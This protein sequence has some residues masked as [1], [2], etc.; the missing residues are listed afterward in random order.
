MAVDA[1]GRAEFR[2]S[3]AARETPR[4]LAVVGACFVIITVTNSLF[5]PPMALTTIVLNGLV[6]LLLLAGALVTQRKSLP[7]RATPWVAAG[8]ALAMVTDGQF[9][10]WRDPD[11]PAFA[12]VL[13]IVV[14]Y[15]PLTLAWTP[16]LVVAVPMVVGSLAVARAFPPSQTTDWAIASVAAIAIGM[17]LLWLRLRS[18]AEAGELSARVQ[19]MATEDHLTG[20]LNRHGV[21][22]RIPSLAA[23]AAERRNE[24]V[25]AVFLDIIGLKRANDTHGHGF[26]DEVITIV[27]DALKASVRSGDIVGR[28]GGDEFLVLGVGQAKDPDALAQRVRDCIESGETALGSWPVEFSVGSAMLGDRHAGVEALILEADHD[29]Y[30]RRRSRRA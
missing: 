13:L 29:M 6:A 8:C 24:E 11:G 26:G 5:G 16:S 12:Y 10:V 14:A 19:A 4:A 27:A 20:L 1:A 2:L 7:A 28:W 23:S 9:Q 22:Q 18:I 30:T 25:F 21:E 15:S 3:V 17:S